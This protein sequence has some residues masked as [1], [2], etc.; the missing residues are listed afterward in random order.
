[1]G[2]EPVTWL[3]PSVHKGVFMPAIKIPSSCSLF[4][5]ILVRWQLFFALILL[6]DS[7]QIFPPV[8]RVSFLGSSSSCAFLCHHY[9]HIGLPLCVYVPVAPPGWEHSQSCHGTDRFYLTM[10]SSLPGSSGL[11]RQE[12]EC[13]FPNIPHFAAES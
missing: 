7:A 5:L 2:L 12:L 3:S 10:H 4:L 11:Q 9:D 13:R 1:M 6:P 8:R